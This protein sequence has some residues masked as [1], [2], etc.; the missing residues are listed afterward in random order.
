MLLDHPLISERYFF[1]RWQM[2]TDPFWVECDGARLAC[3][4]YSPYPQAGTL[5]HF[6]GNGDTAADY[7]GEIAEAV[8]GCGVN[9]CFA[10]YRGYGAATGRPA[11]VAL[12]DD[13]SRIFQ[14]LHLP[15]E[16][17]VVMGRSLGS[18][19]ATELVARYP[20]L[21]GLILESGIADVMERLLLR[22]TPAEL[23]CT[24][25]DLAVEVDRY[26]NQAAKLHGYIGP[27]LILHAAQDTLIAVSHAQR[28]YA[29]AGGVNKELVVFADGDH[30]S[31]MAD[32]WVAYWA[33]LRSFLD[34]ISMTAESEA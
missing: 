22:V 6:H 24:Q 21:A 26:F 33:K 28:N 8:L 15:P 1:P 34:R 10:E 17:V 12:L 29:W 5:L 4:R 18:L 30:N 13:T 19:Y 9:V 25:A 27:V 14:A 11:L 31:I 2:A 23:H 32:N 20:N 3:Y 16:R 7:V